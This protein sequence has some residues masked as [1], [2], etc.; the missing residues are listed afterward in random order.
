DF[1]RCVARKT[2][3]YALGRALGLSD[4]PY[5]DDVVA[6]FAANDRRFSD[7][8]VALVTS[9]PFRMRRGDPAM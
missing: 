9:E 1:L 6:D 8:V 3:I 7:L 2:F 5:I 4:V